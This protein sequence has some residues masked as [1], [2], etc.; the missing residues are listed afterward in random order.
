MHRQLDPIP[1]SEFGQHPRVEQAGQ[2][3][4][5]TQRPPPQQQRLP[6]SAY[7]CGT[8]SLQQHPVSQQQQ[9]A[10]NRQQLSLKPTS[11]SLQLPGDTIR[12]YGTASSHIYACQALGACC[13]MLQWLCQLSKPCQTCL[14]DKQLILHCVNGEKYSLSTPP[15]PFCCRWETKTAGSG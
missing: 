7:S 14:K 13:F 1:V 8:S 9:R 2:Q 11:A 6:L 10:S 5:Q 12:E 15:R 3:L 4:Q